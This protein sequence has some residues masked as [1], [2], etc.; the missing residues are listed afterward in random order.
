MSNMRAGAAR[1]DITPP[2]PVDLLGYVRRDVAARRV[3][4]PLLAT[5]VLVEDDGGTVVIIA[6]DLVNLAPAFAERVRERVAAAV[7]CRPEQVLLN[8]SH[9]H[10]APWPGAGR[11]LG[12]ETDDWTDRELG[13]WESLPDAFASVAVQASHAAVD[14]RVSGAVGHAPGLAV[15]RRERTADGRTILGWNPDGFIDDSVP[16]VRIDSLDGSAIATLVGFGCHP[17]VVGPDV[18]AVGSDFVGPLRRRTEEL[19]GGVA[20]FLQGAAGNVLP[21]EAFFDRTGPE[22]A[23]GQRL[24]LEAAHAVVDQDPRVAT[25]ERLD[26][27]S[28]TPISLYRRRVASEQPRQV[29][30]SLARVV[31]LPLLEAPAV[32]VLESELAE[33]EAELRDRLASGEGRVTTNPVRYHISWLRHML[34]TAP[35]G[36]LPAEVEGEIWAA[37]LGDCAVVGTPGEIFGEIGAAVRE[38]SPA[39]VTIFAGYCGGV[40][41]YVATPEEYPHGGYE[42]AVSHRGYGHPAP[43]SPDVAGIIRDTSLELLAGLFTD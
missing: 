39:A 3:H 38:A 41:G 15:N 31:R 21:L 24:G 37:R 35:Q 27:G 7:S 30:A 2:L 19:R 10:A 1:V 34:A 25:V 40:L 9:S 22:V 11:K 32:A 26:F 13:Y 14:A 42:P 36:D 16:T 28:V 29:L 4:D 17:V 8:S 6:A 23:F 5:G 12:G 43:F 20:V 33:R 18:P